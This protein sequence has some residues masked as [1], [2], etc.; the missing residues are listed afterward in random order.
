MNRT[1]S[2][3]CVEML[4]DVSREDE[5]DGTA[6]AY[7][8]EQCLVVRHL[9]AGLSQVDIGGWCKH[10]TTW[11]PHSSELVPPMRKRRVRDSPLLVS[12]PL[13]VDERHRRR[14]G[15]PRRPP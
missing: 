8:L 7:Y 6:A 11:G 14:V 1:P 5:S 10:T 9:H 12:D 4:M 13:G 15:G 3:G 2:R